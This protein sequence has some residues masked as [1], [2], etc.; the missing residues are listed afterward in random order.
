MGIAVRGNKLWLSA[1]NFLYQYDLADDGKAINR[2]TLLEDKHKAWNPFGIFVLEWGPDGLLYVSVGNHEIDILGPD[3]ELKARGSSGV[4]MRMN[5]DGTKMERL[6]QGMRV[7]YSFEFDPFGQLWVL[8]NGEGNPNRFI[9]VIDGVDYHCFTRP[10]DNNWLSRQELPLAPPCF[11]LLR[12]Q[13]IRNSCVITEA[14]FQSVIKAAC[15]WTTGAS[16][17]FSWAQ[18]RGLF[19][20]PRRP[21]QHRQQRAPVELSRPALPPQLHRAR[22]PREPA[23]RRLV[24]PRR[25]KRHDRP[26]L[27]AEVHG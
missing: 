11:E 22:S 16:H 7:P 14:P 10:V 12:A 18:P 17:G 23:C 15:Y 25:R 6:A 20:P 9:R 27:A 26:H 24:R 4:V 1:N 8:S 19:L 3:G 2:K 13:P 21:R 5:P